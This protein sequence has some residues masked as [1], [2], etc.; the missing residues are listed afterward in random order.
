VAGMP[1]ASSVLALVAAFLFA[2]SVTLQQAAARAA[3]VQAGTAAPTPPGQR[4]GWLPVLGLLTRL[5]RN[6]YWLA[7]WVLNVLGFV[8]HA[9]ALHLGSITAVQAILVF[10]LM[11]ALMLAA[12][13]YRR[14]PLPRD[15][16]GTTAVCL[17]VGLLVTLRGSIAQADAPHER[18]WLATAVAIGLIV[19]I[20]AVARLIGHRA[21]TR[22][23]LVA[24]GAGTC[25]CM[26]AVFVTVL[27]ADVTRG[28][29]TAAA[30]WPLACL[31][32][33]A[34]VGSLLVQESF[35]SGSLPTALTSMT[36][37][38]PVASAVAGVVVFDA[39]PPAGL[40]AL[41]GLPVAVTLTVIGVILL[42]Y[43][44]TLHD[45]RSLSAGHAGTGVAAEQPGHRGRPR[46]PLRRRPSRGASVPSGQGE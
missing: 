21:Q 24:V 12:V 39:A 34:I 33:S 28:G 22:S 30:S 14:R 16:A 36:I 18:V 25:F 42:A 41:V 8:A 7:G 2:V 29:L 10:Q 40:E 43:S 3:A 13:L 4:R 35:A 17:G 37:T 20:L 27:T 19:S 11:F 15:W 46:I 44:P 45:E 32:I 9:A 1:V 6:P 5:V 38:D 26:T 23:A 31:V